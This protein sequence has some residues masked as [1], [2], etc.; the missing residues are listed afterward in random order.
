MEKLKERNQVNPNDCWDLTKVIRDEQEYEDLK[1]IVLLK[2]QE[3]LQMKGHILDNR[4]SLLKF[5]TISEEESRALGR[6]VVYTKFLYD[7]NTKDPKRKEKLLEIESLSNQVSESESFVM[8]ELMEKDLDTVLSFISDS[9]EL[10]GYT[11][12]F[13]EIYKDKA[14]ILSEQEEK[15]IASCYNAFGTPEDAFDSLDVS[16]AKFGSILVDGKEVE[17]T[18]YNYIELLQHKSQE[19]RRDAFH[20]FYQYYRNHKNTYASLLQ[21]NYQELEFT[22][23]IRKYSTALDMALDEI[24]VPRSVYEN[25]ISVVH[26]YMDINVDYQKL[27]AR[28]LGEKEYHIYDTYVPVIDIPTKKFTKDEAISIVSKALK[29]LK[30]DYL[31]HFQ[32]I[33]DNHTVDFYPNVGKQ[34][35]AY[36]WGCYDSPSYV[37]L[38]FNGT[39]DS[40]STLAHELGHAVHSSYSKE[41]NPYIYSGYEIFLA[42][43]ASTVNEM[44]LSNYLLKHASQKEEKIYYLC[45][46]LDK[47]KAT[48]YRQ[49]MFS[50]F[51]GIMSK[52]CQDKESLTEKNFS[53][54]YFKLNEEYFKDS[55]ILDEDI[56]YEGYR[57]S[58]FY[59]PFYVYQYATGLICAINI[60]SDILDKKE[61]IEEKYIEFLKSG[62]SMNVLDILKLVDIDLTKEDSFE[63]AFQLIYKRFQ[64]LNSLVNGGEFNE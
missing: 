30:E 63:K 35:G 43:I 24:H 10:K 3:I 41:T 40:V 2:M 34:T 14:R 55:T 19:V 53:D 21:G 36:Q 45:E 37:L 48:I 47:V 27:K 54:T 58:H 38:N 23:N 52:K 17:V 49:T 5:V 15:I 6:L 39:L 7:E 62:S 25:L 26:K 57:I 42:E 59:R 33:F 60:V 50:E 32:Q 61:G 13:Q 44:L 51:E 12:Y 56:R 28:M 20:T 9:D 22:R 4:D 8:S 29:P 18:H 64:E 1:K 46:F 16:D 11:R 31:K